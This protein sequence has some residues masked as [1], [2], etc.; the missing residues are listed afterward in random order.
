MKKS[1]A[2]RRRIL[3]AAA[4]MFRDKGYAATTLN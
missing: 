2:S 3:D 1:E 4:K